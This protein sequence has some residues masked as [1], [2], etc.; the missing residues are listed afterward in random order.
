MTGH[1]IPMSLTDCGSFASEA[2]ICGAVIHEGDA[3]YP[4]LVAGLQKALESESTRPIAISVAFSQSIPL[5]AASLPET[6]DVEVVSDL[7]REWRRDTRDP[8]S[9][10]PKPIGL[11]DT[12]LIQLL[13]R[14][15]SQVKRFSQYTSQAT[16]LLPKH[17]IALRS[18]HGDVTDGSPEMSRLPLAPYAL[19]PA[20]MIVADSRD[21][22]RAT[23]PYS[24]YLYSLAVA[25]VDPANPVK[26]AAARTAEASLPK[27]VAAHY[28]ADTFLGPDYTHFVSVP[29]WQRFKSEL[30][31]FLTN[32]DERK[33]TY[34]FLAD[35]RHRV[36][37]VYPPWVLM[38][39]NPASWDMCSQC[40]L[41][42][43]ETV[44][45]L[46]TMPVH[47]LLSIPS[48]PPRLLMGVV[49]SE[50]E[51]FDHPRRLTTLV[52]TACSVAEKFGPNCVGS[53]PHSLLARSVRYAVREFDFDPNNLNAALAWHPNLHKSWHALGFS[54]LADLSTCPTPLLV[55]AWQR[56]SRQ[57]MMWMRPF[58]VPSS[59]PSLQRITELAA[60]VVATPTPSNL[61][62][63]AYMNNQLPRVR[64]AF[65]P[66]LVDLILDLL[67]SDEVL[68][69]DAVALLIRSSLTA[70]LTCRT[71][72]VLCSE[73]GIPRLADRSGIVSE[74]I[75]S[76]LEALLDD[77]PSRSD[78]WLRSMLE[79]L[80]VRR[81]S[82]PIRLASMAVN[83]LVSITL[84]AS[85]P[86]QDRQ[87]QLNRA[88][89]L[90]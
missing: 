90:S 1:L 21:S 42:T 22:G 55:E 63:F 30:A 80:V 45:T 50:L 53:V 82:I 13:C 26:D 72:T 31:A 75:Y 41:V 5:S 71:L 81:A 23:G 20:P 17:L 11:S 79:H 87:W 44:N 78:P 57:D 3:E 51:G 34:Q 69:D 68:S 25:V 47:A 67:C 58:T 12:Q 16:T 59:P 66:T 83:L 49:G 70:P 52:H 37:G 38:L 46:R 18:D 14:S 54:L 86:L 6:L 61:L 89:D 27:P 43:E 65:T 7:I 88:V 64:T 48:T 84:S 77:D 28:S 9:E 76:R 33:R 40:K 10:L 73:R 4:K 36:G 29:E 60:L 56:T 8:A 35:S 24:D 74:S 32:A 19:R 62:L 2:E 39:F 15:P 85:A